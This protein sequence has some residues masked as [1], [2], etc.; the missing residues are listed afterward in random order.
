VQIGNEQNRETNTRIV[1]GVDGSKPSREALRWALAEAG[2]REAIVEAVNVWHY[3]A[4][5]YVPGIVPTPAFAREDFVAAAKAELDEAVDAVLGEGAG[6][7]VELRRVVLEGA[8]VER[9]VERS[10]GA[11]LVVV[12]NRGRGGFRELLL[13]SVAHQCSAHARCPVVIVRP[14]AH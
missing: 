3:P 9:L 5:T 10:D 6:S 7:G 2:R 1:V 14:S 11:E 12:G 4:V 13:G 8:A